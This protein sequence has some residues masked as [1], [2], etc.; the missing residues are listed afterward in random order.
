MTVLYVILGIG[1]FCLLILYIIYLFGFRGRV[2]YNDVTK[3]HAKNKAPYGKFSDDI[4]KGVTYINGLEGE[5]VTTKSY[6]GTVLVGKYYSVPDPKAVIIL[7]HGYRSIAKNDFSCALEYFRNLG[8]DLILID[9][10]GHGESGGRTITFGVKERYDCVAW[11]EYAA[12]RWKDRKIILEGISMGA[13]TVL[14]AS[15]LPMPE[16]VVG[17][18]A[19]C[20]YTSP[21]EIIT[22]VVNDYHAPGKFLYKVARFSAKMFGNFDPEESSAIEAVKHCTK[23]ILFIHGEADDF[24]PCEMTK[25]MFEACASKEKYLVTVADAGHGLSFVIDRAKVERELFEFLEKVC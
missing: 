15:E 6:D 24:V 4:L 16:N 1:I 25:R 2:F 14:M 8:F 9:Q 18:I 11:A 22:K 3:K 10:R 13:A 19:D 5:T 20:G 17:Y 21:K 23:P 7:H 12:N